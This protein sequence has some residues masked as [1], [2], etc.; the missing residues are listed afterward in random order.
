[1][2]W[3]LL[4]AIPASSR[5]APHFAGAVLHLGAVV[6]TRLPMLVGIVAGAVLAPGSA[7]LWAALLRSGDLPRAGDVGFAESI[8]HRTVEFNQITRGDWG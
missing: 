3:N 1:V 2:G 4:A 8:A 5:R 7:T 6:R